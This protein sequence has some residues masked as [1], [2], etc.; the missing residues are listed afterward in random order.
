MRAKLAEMPVPVIDGLRLPSDADVQPLGSLM[1]SAY[2]GTIDDE[3][4]SE[5]DAL[6]EVQKT[7]AGAYGSF[8]PSCSAVVER[9]GRLLSATLV[10]RWQ[11]R[12]FVAFS[13]TE[14][15]FK[16]NGLARACMMAAMS[17]LH[18]AGEHELGLV[19]TL[20]NLPAFNLYTSLGFV[21]GE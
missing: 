2:R 17:R 3:G 11:D 19:V 21:V 10:T 14:P 7:Y 8:V 13:M 5:A 1:H 15:N 12:P 20:A 9:G 6:V 4:E 18:A 16:R